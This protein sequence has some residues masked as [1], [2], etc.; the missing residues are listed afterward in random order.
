MFPAG[1]YS[2]N[3]GLSLQRDLEDS[4]CREFPFILNSD[5]T[6][7][8]LDLFKNPLL[9]AS[10]LFHYFFNYRNREIA[11]EDGDHSKSK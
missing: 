5:I 7:L 4:P 3:I 9:V 6:S 2:G 11:K 10:H 1:Q 8:N